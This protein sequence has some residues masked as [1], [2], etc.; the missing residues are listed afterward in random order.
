MT[1]VCVRLSNI[2]NVCIAKVR[3]VRHAGK[4]TVL[5]TGGEGFIGSWVAD[6]LLARG[7]DVVIVDEIRSFLCSPPPV[8]YTLPY[9]ISTAYQS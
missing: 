8:K 5:V 4:K 7:D 1:T 3:M 6:T 9:F 2:V